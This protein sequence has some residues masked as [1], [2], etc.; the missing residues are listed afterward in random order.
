MRLAFQLA[1]QV[2]EAE[3]GASFSSQFAAWTERAAARNVSIV[4]ISNFHILGRYQ[5]EHL[6]D[7]VENAFVES[8]AITLVA[9]DSNLLVE[10][11]VEGLQDVIAERDFLYIAY[12]PKHAKGKAGDF[13]VS[14]VNT[15]LV[16]AHSVNAKAQDGQHVSICVH[17]GV[18]GG[19]S[20]CR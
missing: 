2:E 4:S 11:A 6:R 15:H 18:P 16:R 12:K 3:G 14:D 7:T 10:D 19:T 13:F 8:D 17:V 20:T 9:G 5:T 1:P